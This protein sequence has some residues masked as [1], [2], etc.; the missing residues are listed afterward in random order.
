MKIKKIETFILHVP[1]TRKEIADSTHAITHWGMP[2]VL[3]EAEDGTKGYG[4]TGTHAFLPLDRLITDCI[5]HTFAPLLIG[6]DAMEAES[7]NE[8]MLRYSPALW[9]GRGGITQMAVSAIDIALWDLKAKLLEMPLWKLLGGRPEKRLEAYN[10]DGGWLNWSEDELVDDSRRLVE[11][12]GFPGLKIKLGK[13]SPLE[14]LRRVEA[15]RR[16]VGPEPKLMVD[17]NGRWDLNHAT[18]VGQH[19]GEFDII[20]FEEPMWHHDISGHAQ[21]ARR[22]ST[23][24]ALGELLYSIDDFRHFIEMQAVHFIQ[25]DAVRI[26]GV[27]QWWKVADMGYGFRL[28]VVPHHGDGGQ[29]QLHLG[30]AHSGCPSL[31]Y[32]PWTRDCFV[33][34]MTVRDGYYV[35][36]QEPGAG[37]TLKPECMESYRAG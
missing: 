8:V 35:L 6:R 15:V 16:A 21:L 33:E 9:V 24:I 4:Y 28:P 20:W 1:V 30:A 19:L 32:I 7:L 14:D 3:I 29:V 13:E 18:R 36:P 31:E 23:P 37:T 26:G 11:E 25:V 10:T 27:T 22:I 12:E 17:A 2:G 5:E 34:P